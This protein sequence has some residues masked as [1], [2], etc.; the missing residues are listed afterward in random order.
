MD[1]GGEG[2]SHCFHIDF[3]FLSLTKKKTRRLEIFFEK[4][5]SSFPLSNFLKRQHRVQ[6]CQRKTRKNT[7]RALGTEGQGRPQLSQGEGGGWGKP[8][9]QR[10]FKFR[11]L[12]SSWGQQPG[13]LMEADNPAPL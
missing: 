8:G 3:F 7:H 13:G 9:K 11:A 4:K 5:Q 12:R 10:V 6:L 2:E 1:D